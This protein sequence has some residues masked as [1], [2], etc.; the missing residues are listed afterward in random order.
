MAKVILILLVV[1]ALAAVC[2]AQARYPANVDPA[3]CPNY[4]YCNTAGIG[5]P[6]GYRFD[7]R[8]GYP[9]GINAAT[10]P[11]YPYC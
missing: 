5:A 9:P 1:A 4:P 11:F 10:C 2:L 7:D 8:N 3:S 6:L